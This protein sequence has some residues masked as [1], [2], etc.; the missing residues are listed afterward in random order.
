M[1]KPLLQV[2]KHLVF[3]VG[4]CL[5]LVDTVPCCADTRHSLALNFVDLGRPLRHELIKRLLALLILS[6]PFL[7]FG[8]YF[9]HPPDIRIENLILYLKSDLTRHLFV[10]ADVL[11]NY[12]FF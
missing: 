8:F 11:V 7:V 6:L 12:L 3:S 9:A 4:H 1:L 2:C 10:P 5:D